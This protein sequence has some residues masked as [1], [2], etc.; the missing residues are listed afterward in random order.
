MRH[1]QQDDHRHGEQRDT[2]ADEDQK[3]ERVPLG[4][5]LRLG[6]AKERQR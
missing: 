4:T 6:D 1:E 5:G 3:L 2:T